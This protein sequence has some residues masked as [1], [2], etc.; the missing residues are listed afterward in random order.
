VKSFAAALVVLF[1]ASGDVFA[2]RLDE[3]LQ[4]TRVSF[5]RDQLAIDVDLTPGVSIASGVISMLDTNADGAIAPAE[6]EAY[7]RT[8][9]S[10]LLL[11]LDGNGVGMT[12]E[13][14]EIPTLDEMRNG[15][16]TIRLRAA[17]SVE[18]GSGRHRL[19]L[20]NNHRPESSV[21]M[22]NALVPEDRGV[23]IVSQ[24][25]DSRQR[26]FQMETIVRP[27]WPM[28]LLWLGLGAA[29][30]TL[31]MLGGRSNEKR[32][33]KNELLMAREDS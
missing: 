9:L 8:V 18:N 20:L 31:T 3:Y 19:Q 32:I 2:H 16:G 14:I 29:V 11:T 26:E 30:V 28:R 10:D 1:A 22:V 4:A 12:L 7:G 6:G 13:R 25:R 17:V 23:V 33:T 27:Q 5:A 15:M 24:S 21:Y